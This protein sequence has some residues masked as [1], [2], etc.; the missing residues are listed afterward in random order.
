MLMLPD[1]QLFICDTHVNRDP[2]AEQ[3]AEITLL[4]AEE[5]RRFG[6]TP[7]VALLSHSSFGGSDAPS[8]QQD[9]RGAGAHPA[10]ASRS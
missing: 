5:V 9:A 2:S 7:R 6:V 8:A 3:I 4:A 10:R 1:R